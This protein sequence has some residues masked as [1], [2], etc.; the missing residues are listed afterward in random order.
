MA[1]D[2]ASLESRLADIRAAIDAVA[3]EPQSVTSPT[4]T[5]H[6]EYSLEELMKL[7][8]RLITQINDAR[9]KLRRKNGAKS[10]IGYGGIY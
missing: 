4:G 10:R 3:V 9:R 1:E 5:S 2:I 8:R 6:T 7:E